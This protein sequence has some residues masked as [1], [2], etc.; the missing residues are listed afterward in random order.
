MEAIFKGF[1]VENILTIS[2]GLVFLAMFFA[3]WLIKGI[4]NGN[5]A[6]ERIPKETISLV[7]LYL[8]ASV[9]FVVVGTG[10][11]IFMNDAVSLNIVS[12]DDLDSLKEMK[13]ADKYKIFLSHGGVKQNIIEKP[14]KAQFRG[15]KEDINLSSTGLILFIDKQNDTIS[16]LTRYIE[17]KNKSAQPNLLPGNSILESAR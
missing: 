13:I 2:N 15:G 8:A 3:F 9:F 1:N 11:Q 6:D 4:I 10:M 5:K 12:T 7:K 16:E 14:Y 17:N